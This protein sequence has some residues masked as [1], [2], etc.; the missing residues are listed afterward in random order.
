MT[1]ID[2]EGFPWALE[3]PS[4][5]RFPMETVHIDLAYPE[6]RAGGRALDPRVSSGS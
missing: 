4:G 1:F 3:V 5:W 2:P 6:F